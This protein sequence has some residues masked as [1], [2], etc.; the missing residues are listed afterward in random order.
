MKKLIRGV[1]FLLVVAGALAI[2]KPDQS[3]FEN[4]LKDYS[5]RKRGNAKGENVVEKL[6]DK[7]VTTAE[8][9][10]ILATYQYNN[11]Y[12]FSTV[13]AHANG[14]KLTFVGVAGTWIPL[15]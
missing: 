4:W 11:H 13:E 5:A 10:Q 2:F 15:P 12:V 6:V 1:L 7:G 9:L 3:N 14:E 8:Q